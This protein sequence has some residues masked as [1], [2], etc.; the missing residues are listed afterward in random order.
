MKKC[1]LYFTLLAL[2]ILIVIYGI[3]MQKSTHADSINDALGLL[4]FSSSIDKTDGKGSLYTIDS[5]GNVSDALKTEGLELGELYHHN[6][7]VILNDV[8]TSY[9]MENEKIIEEERDQKEYTAIFAGYMNDKRVELYNSGYDENGTY[10]SHLYWEQD[11]SMQYQDLPYFITT[12]GIYEDS[13]YVLEEKEADEVMTLHEITLG[14]TIQDDSLFLPLDYKTDELVPLTDMIVTE[15]YI[16]G[17]VNIQQAYSVLMI[18]KKTDEVSEKNFLS[19]DSSEEMSAH[20]PHSVYNSIHWSD[21]Q[22]FF[23]DGQG[24]LYQ[25]NKDGELDTTYD[26][27]DANDDSTFLFPSWSENKLYLFE[28]TNTASIKKIDLM[29]LEV[30]DDLEL[31][32]DEFFG[33]SEQFLYDFEMIN[34]F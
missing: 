7:T 10:H 31:D 23:L 6:N 34:G 33:V 2:I 14:E 20:L 24:N 4:Y 11:G 29:E 8:S 22:L 1:L 12:A 17:I 3:V 9:I 27:P 25:F 19:F 13:L 18:N 15:E 26:I 28:M 5:S 21:N 32:G 30:E 16:Y